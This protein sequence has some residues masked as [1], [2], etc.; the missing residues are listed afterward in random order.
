MKLLRGDVNFGRLLAVVAGYP[1]KFAR[2]AWV[3]LCETFLRPLAPPLARQL[4]KLRAMRRPVTFF[5]ADGDPGYELLKAGA[6]RTT[7]RM[8]AK[9]A[10]RIVRIPNADHTFSQRVPRQALVEA[11]CEELS[12]LP[13]GSPARERKVGSLLAASA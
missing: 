7:S 9:G 8:I 13:E 11:V 5:I 6:P 1:G 12:A 2:R 10:V 3:A 4:R